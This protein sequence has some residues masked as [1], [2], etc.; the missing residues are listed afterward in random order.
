MV[1]SEE[2]KLQRLTAALAEHSAEG[3]EILSSEPSRLI[4]LT[5][6]LIIGLLVCGV[7]WSFI[8]RADIIV[9]VPGSLVPEADVQ[10]VYAPIKGDL[11]D[12]YVAEGMPV[13]K[14]DV[15]F[16]LNARDVV[17]TAAQALDAR[18]KLAS[19]QREYDLYPENKRLSEMK[20]EAFKLTV[21]AEEA[22]YEQRMSAGMEKLAEAQKLQLEKS[23]FELKRSQSQ[24]DQAKVS[25]EKFRR[26][27]NTPGGGG[28][29]RKQVEEKKQAYQAAVT[30]YKLEETKL[31][32][33]EINLN[34]EYLNK[35]YEV[36]SSYQQLAEARA[37]VETEVLKLRNLKSQVDVGLKIAR[38]NADAASRIS[39]DNIDEDNFLRI[40]A[41]TSGVVTY[42][43]YS[44]TGDKI[45][46]NQSV[47][48]IAAENSRMILQVEIPEVSRGLLHE[49]MPV[50]MKFNAFHF[51]RYGFIEG[52]LEFISPNTII[53]QQS[54][55]PVY[56]GVVSLEKTEFVSGELIHPLRYGMAAQAEIIVERRRLIDLALDPFKKLQR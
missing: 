14:G 10:R 38:M 51:Q 47:V 49:E 15:L 36:R 26:L 12:I 28:V 37:R 48:G 34:K 4:R 41:P 6:L 3:I 7:A 23:R 45:P 16:R 42:V 44:Q 56:K 53:S 17:Q 40:L 32:E 13:S 50:K 21:K 22:V 31:G 29:S 24:R 1:N 19:A 33:L 52:T 30:N 20:I 27:F 11:A 5:I 35:L 39:F 8:G 18:I 25:Y 43:A 2:K 46:E 55:K 54:K 9:S